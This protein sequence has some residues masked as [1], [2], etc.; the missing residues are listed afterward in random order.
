MNNACNPAPSGYNENM[1]TN[2]TRQ[3][4]KAGMSQSLAA[5]AAGMSLR[6]LQNYDC[7]HRAINKASAIVVL[8][9]ADALG[10][11]VRDILEPEDINGESAE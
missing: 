1:E 10:C 8:R 2:L 4:N 6:S 7:G 3:R 9:L 5:K 11:E